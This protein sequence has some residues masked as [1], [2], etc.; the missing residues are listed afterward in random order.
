MRWGACFVLSCFVLREMVALISSVK[1][2]TGIYFDGMNGSIILS[3]FWLSLL[4]N[5]TISELSAWKLYPF[6]FA[7]D[8]VVSEFGVGM[9]T[10]GN[11]NIKNMTMVWMAEFIGRMKIKEFC[12]C[13]IIEYFFMWKLENLRSIT[14]VVCWGKWQWPT[15]L[16]S[17][18]KRG[19]WPRNLKFFIKFTIQ[20]SQP[21]LLSSS[22]QEFSKLV[23]KFSVYISLFSLPLVK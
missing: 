6:Y 23:L 11:S 3:A 5:K 18:T 14:G 13:R 17:S 16:K 10:I 2:P 22:W 20:L 15:G 8:S 1:S 7:Q 21:Y 9:A 12:E 19:K 4:Y